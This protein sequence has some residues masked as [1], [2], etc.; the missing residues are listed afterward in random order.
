MRG[1]LCVMETC[2]RGWMFLSD[3]VT[4]HQSYAPFLRF[5]TN[6]IFAWACALEMPCGIRV[7]L[8]SHRWHLAVGSERWRRP[9]MQKV[10]DTMPSDLNCFL[11]AFKLYRRHCNK[12]DLFGMA[13]KL[14]QRAEK[15]L[16]SICSL[17][18]ASWQG[19]CNKALREVGYNSRK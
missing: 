1:M 12:A 4:V 7:R 5:P 3:Q 16:A 11:Q 8:Q 2:T 13:K 17:F 19:Y 9:G 15:S 6:S 14:P 10:F 18:A